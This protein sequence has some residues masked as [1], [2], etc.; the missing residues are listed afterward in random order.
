MVSQRSLITIFWGCLIADFPFTSA[1]QGLHQFHLSRLPRQDLRLSITADR[2]IIQNNHDRTSASTK[3]SSAVLSQRPTSCDS[4]HLQMVSFYKFRP[5][6]EPLALRDKVFDAMV[7]RV[8]GLRGSLYV[9]HE[10]VNGQFAVPVEYVK[11]FANICEAHLGCLGDALNWGDVVPVDTPTF[12]RLIVRSR[13]AILRDGLDETQ[14]NSIDW[15]EAGLVL[16]PEKWDFEVRAASD[17][18]TTTTTP[19]PLILDCRNGYESDDGRFHNAIPL[20][21]TAFSETWDVLNGIAESVDN[22]NQPVFIYCTGGIR[23]VK[24]GAYMQQSLG[25]TNVKRLEHGIIGYQNWYEGRQRSA[26]TEVDLRP[27]LWEGK[28]FLFDKRRIV[29]QAKG[30]ASS[31]SPS[32]RG[33]MKI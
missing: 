22:K 20:N 27:W 23:C 25:F 12:Q 4:L 33:R 31:Q 7:Q 26:A 8:P 30:S 21:T 19:H 32:S 24:V 18:A 10:G 9:A 15:N 14:I 6:A 3:G 1:F 5:I 16:S 17:T 29:E 2:N 11:E 13:D 28:N